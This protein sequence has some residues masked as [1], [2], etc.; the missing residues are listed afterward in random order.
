MGIQ[1]NGNTD[2]ISAVDGDLSITGITTFS[3]LDVGNNIKLGNA[4]V[5]T[6]TSFV[7]SGA[8][9]TGISPN[10][11]SI[12]SN[13]V[14]DSDN[15]RDL[16]TSSARWNELYIQSIKGNQ[17]QHILYDANGAIEMFANSTQFI[18]MKVNG[19]GLEIRNNSR[20]IPTTSGAINFGDASNKWNEIHANSFH[21]DGSNL[22]GITGTTINNNADDRVITGS[23]T[24]NT[25]NGESLVTID[26]SGRLSVAP[27]VGGGGITVASSGSTFGGSVKLRNTTGSNHD[28]MIAVGGGDG[29]YVNGRGMLI[30]DNTTG[31]NHTQ[32]R[33]T[34]DLA[35]TDGNLVMA[36]GHGI[37]FSATGGVT[38][39]GASELF[40]DYEE[41]SFTA[42]LSA[43]GGG[44]T[45]ASGH[46]QTACLYVKIG[47][48]CHVQGYFSGTNVT[49]GGTGIVKVSGLPFA[50]NN[51]TYYTLCL[52]HNTMTAQQCTG[53][54]IQYA[55]TYFFPIQTGATSGSAFNVGNPRYL[56]FGGSY[57][58]QF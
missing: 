27:S 37:D 13:I 3:Q 34:G 9:L 49:G 7:G 24:A 12:A 51:T 44:A 52:T 54:Y 5:V 18:G 55:N 46:I 30:R 56:M 32:F 43:S 15:A 53:A 26:S 28:W 20:V 22:T 42:T 38:S 40:D 23:G 50:S 21:G 14:P 1:I 10:F 41:G 6:A 16:G 29:A 4:G 45:F 35:I 39:G 58:V 19:K 17:N 2:N 36:S 57:P 47:S 11:T 48:M 25:L 8:N 33:T 31:I